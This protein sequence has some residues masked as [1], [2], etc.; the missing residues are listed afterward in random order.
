[1]RSASVICGSGGGPVGGNPMKPGG[2]R[3]RSGSGMAPLGPGMVIGPPGPDIPGGGR[4]METT[5]MIISV[6]GRGIDKG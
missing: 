5:A 1:M 2:G 4:P 6:G 3:L